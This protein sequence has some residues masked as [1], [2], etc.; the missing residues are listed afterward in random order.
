MKSRPVK[1]LQLPLRRSLNLSTDARAKYHPDKLPHYF[2]HPHVLVL[3]WQLCHGSYA[4]QGREGGRLFVK[5]L[6]FAGGSGGH[7][8]TS[9][10]LPLVR[11]SACLST[12]VAFSPCWLLISFPVG[13]GRNVASKRSRHWE[14]SVSRGLEASTTLA[15]L[16]TRCQEEKCKQDE[17]KMT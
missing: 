12:S 2:L 4:I 9:F 6:A 13:L 16:V 7:F 1:Q 8:S 5:F 11:R 10:S 3:P 14:G 15:G 17:R